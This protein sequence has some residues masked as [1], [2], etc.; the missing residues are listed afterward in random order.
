MLK[1]HFQFTFYTI[2]LWFSIF[3]IQASS[4]GL[5]YILIYIG[6]SYS[7]VG[8]QYTRVG[9]TINLSFTLV[10][11]NVRWFPLYVRQFHEWVGQCPW[12]TDIL[13]PENMRYCPSTTIS[14]WL[15][16]GRLLSTSSTICYPAKLDRKQSLGRRGI[17][18]KTSRNEICPLFALVKLA[19]ISLS[20]ATIFG[21]LFSRN[22][23]DKST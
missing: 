5:G 17:T 3:N 19:L 18:D 2:V 12:P 16:S 6:Q 9:Q 13:R 10:G 7:S 23:W 22:L 14:I 11:Q 4:P 1:Q 15:Y 20:H 21:W 8:H